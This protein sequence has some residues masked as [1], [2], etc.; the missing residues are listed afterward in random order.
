MK[1]FKN[2][3]LP[4]LLGVCIHSS[5]A[6]DIAKQ[7]LDAIQKLLQDTQSQ[8]TINKIVENEQDP[9][10]Y[11]N[12]K[13]YSIYDDKGS[14]LQVIVYQNETTGYDA[15]F[16]QNNDNV[17]S[18]EQYD[19]LR[20]LNGVYKNENKV[21]NDVSSYHVLSA[22]NKSLFSFTEST[23]TKNHFIT[24]NKDKNIVNFISS[25]SDNDFPIV[26]SFQITQDGKLVS[27]NQSLVKVGKLSYNMLQTILTKDYNLSN[28]RMTAFMQDETMESTLSI[29]NGVV[30][31]DAL[32]KDFGTTCSLEL[33]K[34]Y[35]ATESTA[36]RCVLFEDAIFSRENKVPI[37]E[38]EALDEGLRVKVID[39]PT[40]YC[41]ENSYIDGIYP[42]K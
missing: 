24:Y 14:S 36:F 26:E 28:V 12:H 19:F 39:G 33:S 6:S 20:K 4:L 30:Y 38:I 7:D 15:S 17:I 25:T 35:A 8:F 27:Q 5:F 1:G 21:D 34:C 23:T 13:I 37:V 42:L 22:K 40:A 3:F 9:A 41:G 16:Y 31:I 18:K 11:V 29:K 10:L 32:N 2:I